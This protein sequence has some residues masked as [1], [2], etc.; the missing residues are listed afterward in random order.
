MVKTK[1]FSIIVLCVTML[2]S[3]IMA[4]C[5]NNTDP[6]VESIAF[7]D[8]TV[9]QTYQLNEQ[10]DY[11]A[12]KLVVSYSDTTT[13]EI[14]LTDDNVEYT[15]IDVTTPGQKVLSA[16]YQNKL[17]TKNVEVVKN[18]SSIEFVQNSIKT[19]YEKDSTINYSSFIVKLNFNDGTS[20]TQSLNKTDF[21]YDEIDT[22]QIGKHNFEVTYN[23][24]TTS[25]EIEIVAPKT[26]ESIEILNLKTVYGQGEDIHYNE[27]SIKF[28]YD[29]DTNEVKTLNTTDF[30]Y[31]EIDTSVPGTKNFVVT[32]KS[33]TQISATK[34]ITVQEAT[35]KSIEYYDGLKTQYQVNGQFNA[36]EVRIKVIKDNNDVE[37]VYLNDDGVDFSA[38][39]SKQ[40]TSNVLNI[41]YGGRYCTTTINVVAVFEKIEFQASSLVFDFN[42]EFDKSLIKLDLIYNDPSVNDVITLD[43]QDVTITQDVSLTDKTLV[44]ETQ[45]L[46]VEYNGKTA[47][48][49]VVVNKVLTGIAFKEGTSTVYYLNDVVDYSKIFIIASYNNDTTEEISLNDART[50]YTKIDTSVT[51][52]VKLQVEFKG[53]TT[54]ELTITV[55]S[56]PRINEFA[57]PL[58]YS[59]YLTKS[60]NTNTYKV[61]RDTATNPYLVGSIN[62]FNFV[63]VTSYFDTTS[64]ERVYIDN[65][66]TIYE[67]FVKE[68]GNYVKVT[69]PDLYLESVSDNMYDFNETANDNFFKLVVSLNPDKNNL[70]YWTNNDVDAPTIEIEFKVVDAYNVYDTYGLSVM[71]NLNVK[72][73]AEIKNR[74]LKYD[75]KKLSEYTNVKLVILHNDIVINAD[76]LPE[77]YFWAEDMFGYNVALENARKADE[78]TGNITNFAGRLKGALRNGTG[79]EGYNHCDVDQNSKDVNGNPRKDYVETWGCLNPQKGIFT[80]NQTSINGNYMTISTKDS[81]TRHLTSIL[82]HR[83]EDDNVNRMTN[84]E[85]HWSIFKFFKTEDLTSTKFNVSIENVT[86]QGNM[87]KTNQQG[88]EAGLMAMNTLADK[89]TI[90]N[91]ITTQFYTH[92]VADGVAG[93]ADSLLEFKNSIMTDAYSNM[94]YMLRSNV[95][96]VNSTL[97]NAGGP[98]FILTDADRLASDTSDIPGPILNVDKDS[99]L[100]SFASGQE[101]WYQMYDATPLLTMLKGNLNNIFNGAT[102]KTFV[103]NV[104]SAEQINI[105]AVMIPDPES[106]FTNPTNPLNIKSTVNIEKANGDIETYDMNDP[107]ANLVKYL[108]SVGFVSNG[109]YAFI[110]DPNTFAIQ[111]WP[112]AAAYDTYFVPTL[113]EPAQQLLT[114]EKLGLTDIPPSDFANSSEFLTLVLSAKLAEQSLT[115]AP[116]FGVLLGDYT[117]E[118][119][120]IT[121]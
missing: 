63:P 60:E 103:H 112:G 102:N 33:N 117:A 52:T 41:T 83:Y 79:Y 40:G 109:N 29:N 24:K 116:Y 84:Q 11:S 71:D 78:K 1:L 62:K 10:I 119:Q 96:I 67:L 13:K 118:K 107:M 81:A 90:S 121:L 66:E 3:T 87:P 14:A 58:S 32:L 108:N 110:S 36:N 7:K 38:D 46:K 82:S 59:Q 80:T 44:G 6:T 88:R 64:F 101:A 49:N 55:K 86:L 5:T 56:L 113:P 54:S 77:N 25:I 51:G 120:N 43:N 15:P 69:S 4:A 39:L 91:V 99:V 75:D 35:V 53:K 72:N 89:I 94:F 93:R 48:I 30:T 105:I 17:A 31:E 42:G 68:D 95:N 16:T 74:T 50:S 9:K 92:I 76:Q 61:A 85:G 45:V 100:E 19:T 26:L 20:T 18:V 12:I 115:N 22:S 65:P 28:N 97:K 111:K 114:S 104:N 98:L 73:W 57:M 37:L 27:I 34:T 47:E 8:G 70:T 2:T 23:N 21:S 106:I